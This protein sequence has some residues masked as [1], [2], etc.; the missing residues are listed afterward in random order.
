VA[1]HATD[2]ILSLPLYP[3]MTDGDVADTVAAVTK[4]IAHSRR[5]AGVAAR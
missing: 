4:V 3:A 1:E 5:S 2:R